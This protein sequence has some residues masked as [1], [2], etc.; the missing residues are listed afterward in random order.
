VI[1]VTRSDGKEAAAPCSCR[2]DNP[3]NKPLCYY[4]KTDIAE[5]YGN[6]TFNDYL[7]G[8]DK[9]Q[10]RA[11][12]NAIAFVK[13]FSIAVKNHT[14]LYLWSNYPGSGKSM[15][16]CV[17]V[18]E[19]CKKYNLKTQAINVVDLYERIRNTFNT[20][21]S[22]LSI[23]NPCIG[24]DVLLL[25]DLGAEKRTKWTEQI[26]YRILDARLNKGRVTFFTSNYSISRL[27]YE[28][29]TKSR[30]NDLSFPINLPDMDIRAKVA[31]QR[32]EY[33][34]SQFNN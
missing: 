16:S 26:L 29:R 23:I 2:R 19:I 17:T 4:F 1:I 24:S 6:K 8:F 3:T 27:P 9:K 22:E 20:D 5:K 15:L 11:K 12:N 14:G 18:T 31:Q 25:D 33:L 21:K 10:D 13:K 30:I 32:N 34:Y 28:G 7:T